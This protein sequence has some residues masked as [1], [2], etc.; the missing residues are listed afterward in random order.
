MAAADPAFEYLQRIQSMMESFDE[1]LSRLCKHNISEA[2]R[3]QRKELM[4]SYHGLYKDLQSRYETL[5]IKEKKLEE[6]VTTGKSEES[7]TSQITGSNPAV[8]K[9][10]SSVPA[11]NE[12]LSSVRVRSEI[13]MLCDKA[14]GRGLRNY[15]MDHRKEGSA[16]KEELFVALLKAP[17]AAKLV[18]NALEPPFSWNINDPIFLL[19]KGLYRIFG[20]AESFVFPS[21]VK[22]SAREIAKAWKDKM[23]LKDNTS[24]GGKVYAVL[25]LKF[26]ASFKIAADYER[27]ELWGL[28]LAVSGKPQTLVL[29][30]CLGL[31]PYVSG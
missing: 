11:F 3:D 9:L 21:D 28:L 2:V 19:L 31:T 30:R 6:P 5:K 29:C 7:K 17:D 10:L 20:K 8:N 12:L 27:N 24:R 23:N 26:L 14:D 16:L 13:E 22:N 25:F 4:D 15:I 1:S 18:L